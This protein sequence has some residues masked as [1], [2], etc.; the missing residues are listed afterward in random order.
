[1]FSLVPARAKI[2]SKHTHTPVDSVTQ[3]HVP[4]V[5]CAGVCVWGDLDAARTLR[6][7]GAKEFPCKEFNDPINNFN[8]WQKIRSVSLVKV[9]IGELFRLLVFS[10]K[11]CQPPSP[12][13][14]I[15]KQNE[16]TVVVFVQGLL[17]ASGDRNDIP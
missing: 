5:L 7:G 13:I 3:T 16:I 4:R 17:A 12:E 11:R 6:I 14:S 1:M 2:P 8:Y 9:K 15:H 10:S